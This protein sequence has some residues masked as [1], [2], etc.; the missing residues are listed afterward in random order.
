[1]YTNM[2]EIE[3]DAEKYKRKIDGDAERWKEKK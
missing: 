1:M 2:I 3:T